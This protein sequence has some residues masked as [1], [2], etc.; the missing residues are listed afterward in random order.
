MENKTETKLRQSYK[1]V[2]LTRFSK[3][4]TIRYFLT[5]EKAVK[6]YNKTIFGFVELVE[7]VHFEMSEGYTPIGWKTL[8]LFLNTKS[9]KDSSYQKCLEAKIIL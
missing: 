6:F 9:A 3:T 5:I 8:K 1:V 2:Y 4:V 7:L